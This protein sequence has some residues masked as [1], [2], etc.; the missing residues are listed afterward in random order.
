M[1]LRRVR[2]GPDKKVWR[3]AVRSPSFSCYFRAGEARASDVG[4]SLGG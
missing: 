3:Y 1:T 4:V 2:T